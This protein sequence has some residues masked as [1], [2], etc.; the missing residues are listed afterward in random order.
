MAGRVSHVGTA[1]PPSS[2]LRLACS[3]SQVPYCLG[4]KLKTQVYGSAGPRLGSVGK[5]DFCI[6]DA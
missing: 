3:M 4:V 5:L 6:T 2:K 1:I